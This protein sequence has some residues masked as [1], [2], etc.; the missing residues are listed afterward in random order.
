[1][2]NSAPN[3]NIHDMVLMLITLNYITSFTQSFKQYP[4]YFISMLKKYITKSHFTWHSCTTESLTELTGSGKKLTN[5]NHLVWHPYTPVILS[6]CDLFSVLLENLCLTLPVRVIDPITHISCYR[7][8]FLRLTAA[9][10]RVSGRT[11]YWVPYIPTRISTGN[12]WAS[13][14]SKILYPLLPN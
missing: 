6:I 2:E 10:G 1:M 8:C 9:F 3:T 5:K 13:F 11:P 12:V 14:L 7:R 4:R